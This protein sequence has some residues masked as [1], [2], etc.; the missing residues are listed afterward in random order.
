MKLRVMNVRR[1]RHRDARGRLDA[2]FNTKSN[3][4]EM[5]V[6]L[7]GESRLE[8]EVHILVYLERRVEWDAVQWFSK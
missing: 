5:Y 7:E 3:T 4:Y 6:A 1:T 8:A 2:Y